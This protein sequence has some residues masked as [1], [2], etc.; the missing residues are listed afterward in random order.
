MAH[1]PSKS[2][3]NKKDDLCKF[4]QKNTDNMSSFECLICEAKVC[5]D[6]HV[7]QTCSE[8]LNSSVCS[9]ECMKKCENEFKPCSGTMCDSVLCGYCL[10]ENRCKGCD[11][12]YCQYCSSKCNNCDCFICDDCLKSCQSCDAIYCDD[13]SYNQGYLN[14]CD[15]CGGG[16]CEKCCSYV[17]TYQSDEEKY[18]EDCYNINR[19]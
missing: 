11:E 7:L 8:C 3:P 4:C 9:R 19:D 14:T 16:F 2:S 1:E 17:N 6:C 13:C 5:T 10:A 18:C 12:Y 15:G